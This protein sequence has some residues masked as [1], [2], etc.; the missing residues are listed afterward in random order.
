MQAKRAGLAG[1]PA[2][3]R[4]A[5]P[6]PRGPRT[7]PARLWH[8]DSPGGTSSSPR[9]RAAC[10]SLPWADRSPGGVTHRNENL[11]H[12]PGASQRPTP[13]SRCRGTRPRRGHR[14][15]GVGHVAALPTPPSPKLPRCWTENYTRREPQGF[16]KNSADAEARDNPMGSD[17]LT[18]PGA[19]RPRAGQC[20]EQ[21][22]EVDLLLD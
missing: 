8:P 11:S 21:E 18:A 14:S 4:L 10:L 13:S 5:D 9:A 20:R 7:P 15:P 22:G 16:V 3:G 17:V 6:S 1:H 19:L 12:I 2:G